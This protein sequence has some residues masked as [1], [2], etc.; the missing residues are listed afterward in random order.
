MNREILFRAK[1]TYDGEWIEGLYIRDI[2]NK[3]RHR[4]QPLEN[5]RFPVYVNPDTICQYIGE[6]DVNGCKVYENDIVMCFNNPYYLAKVVFGEFDVV[7]GDTDRCVDT[8]KGWYFEIIPN[9]LKGNKHI[10]SY[11]LPISKYYINAYNMKVI[12]N[13]FDSKRLIGETKDGESR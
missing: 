3:N 7:D 8:V 13:T 9:T 1:S 6:K 5:W 10:I 4:I 2:E 12:G 11:T